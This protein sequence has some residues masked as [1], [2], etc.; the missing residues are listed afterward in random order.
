ML[1]YEMEQKRLEELL[2]ELFEGDD[3]SVPE[4][5]EILVPPLDPDDFPFFSCCTYTYASY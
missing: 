4:D 1:P 5:L 2:D 3:E